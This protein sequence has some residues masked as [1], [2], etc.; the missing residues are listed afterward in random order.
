MPSPHLKWPTAYDL[1][2]TADG[3]LVACLGRNVVVID[4][5]TRQRVSTSH[6]LPH[7]SH[8]AFSPDGD[9]LAVKS[10]SGRIVV[11]DPRS[12]NI[13]HD[14]KNQ[15]E[16][17]GGPVCFSPDGTALI[18]G[19]W[20]GVVTVRNARDGTILGRETFPGEMI[21]RI[22]HDRDRRTWLIEHSPVVR[23][24]ENHPEPEYLSV[25]QWP[26]APDTTRTLSFGAHIQS[27]TISPD[28]SRI[29][30]IQKWELRQIV[31]VRASD[32]HILASHPLPKVG[33]TGSKLAWSGDSGCIAVVCNGQFAF[34]RASDA[35]VA[36][37]VACEYPSC[38][39]FLPGSDDIL[40]GTWKTTL[41]TTFSDVLAAHLASGRDVPM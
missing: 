7:P 1:S 36:G 15:A 24:G 32:G 12:G 6:P 3:R 14:H 13:L 28:G 38:P 25:R 19:S 40:L 22:S 26:F 29:A 39:L 37:S 33:G 10:T 34:F 16:G 41:V 5:A 31:V 2:C 20:K 23:P 8:A 35:A 27:A 17:E 30:F 18:D 11:I 4:M 9:M 21:T